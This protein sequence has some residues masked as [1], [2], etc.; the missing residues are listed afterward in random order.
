MAFSSFA[1]PARVL[2]PGVLGI[3]EPGCSFEIVGAAP[4]GAKISEVCSLNRVSEI[5]VRYHILNRH[6]FRNMWD[7]NRF[8]AE[9]LLTLDRNR[10]GRKP[11]RLHPSW[12]T[13][14]SP[15]FLWRYKDD[16]QD[17]HI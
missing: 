13:S 16:S 2:P 15:T 11:Q 1:S 3:Q 14:R 5:V 4:R 7:H 9:I 17:V 6:F 8:G 10:L 12:R